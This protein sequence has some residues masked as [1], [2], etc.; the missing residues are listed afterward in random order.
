[1][2]KEQKG[3]T[4]ENV[5]KVKGVTK[6]KDVT[7]VKEVNK[8]PQNLTDKKPIKAP[9]KTQLTKEI[10]KD[11]EIMLNKTPS[12]KPKENLPSKLGLFEI[13]RIRKICLY[14]IF[15]LVFALIIY[16]FVSFYRTLETCKKLEN[17]LRPGEACSASM[18]CYYTDSSVKSCDSCSFGFTKKEGQSSYVCKTADQYLDALS[19]TTGCFPKV[20]NKNEYNLTIE[21][22]STNSD[23]D[24]IKSDYTVTI[25]DN[26][27][28]EQENGVVSLE[29]QNTFNLFNVIKNNVPFF[30]K[31]CYFTIQITLTRDG[32]R[33]ASVSH[34]NM[35]DLS[36]PSIKANEMREVT[37]VAKPKSNTGTGKIRVS[38]NTI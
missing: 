25:K 21:V 15:V 9:A 28:I 8:N 23:Y 16:G 38:V 20:A 11:K 26:E 7:K 22:S 13:T 24:V 10:S 2:I 29:N 12:P 27:F 33:I 36:Y 18:P 4:K 14:T 3:V 30:V 37:I 34:E 6:V 1:M 31:R 35:N 32:L 17:S 5:T 19:V